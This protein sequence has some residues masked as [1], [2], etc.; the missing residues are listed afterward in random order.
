MEIFP[1]PQPLPWADDSGHFEAFFDES[2]K[3]PQLGR[4]RGKGDTEGG[5][6]HCD[7]A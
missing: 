3:P 5:D 7:L 6:L 2:V 1:V 4:D